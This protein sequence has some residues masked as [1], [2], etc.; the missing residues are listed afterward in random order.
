[1]EDT[2]SRLSKRG[3]RITFKYQPKYK[4][5][6]GEQPIAHRYKKVVPMF[7]KMVEDGSLREAYKDSDLSDLAIVTVHNYDE[8]TLIERSLDF[9]GV[10]DYV[11]LKHPG[12]N[13]RMDYKYIYL[14]EFLQECRKPYVLFCDA[15]DIIFTDD[16]AKIVPLFK[17]FEC[18]A[19]CN[20]TMS[21]RGIFK[22]YKSATTL[23]WW[24]R[25]ISRTGWM[26]KYPNAGVFIGKVNFLAELCDVMMFY[27]SKMD[28]RWEPRSDQDIL[29]CIYPWYWPRMQIDYYNKITYRN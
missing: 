12:K 18:E 11:V 10:R 26:K 6:I 3:R 21:P 2:I 23:Y 9:L 24:Y 17:E 8:K 7:E 19:V 1:M 14:S 16:P 20:A 29:R 28:C 22:S 13:W 27:C 4:R 15:R 25:K 5:V